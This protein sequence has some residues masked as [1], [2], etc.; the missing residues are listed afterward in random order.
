V[1]NPLENEESAFRFVLG[2][3][4]YFVPIVVASM[5]STWFGVVTFVGVT[6]FVI[7]RAR[8]SWAARQAPPLQDAGRAAVE[9]TR[10]ILVVGNETLLGERLRDA[11]LRLA[12][13]VAEDV[14]VVCPGVEASAGADDAWERLRLGVQELREA[15]VNVR[16]ETS[17]LDPVRALEDALL[18][19]AADEIVVSTY[20]EGL[21]NWLEDGVV[22][23]VRARFDGPVTHVTE[24]PPGGP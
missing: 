5:I 17:P 23:A 12:D 14:L 22:E 11:V 18:R 2:T 1:R 21:S 10:R 6:A 9:D 3:I 19:F 15:G 20:E 16:G 8:R 13:G 4:A 7:L 24:R